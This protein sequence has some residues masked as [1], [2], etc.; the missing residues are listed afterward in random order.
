MAHLISS[1]PLNPDHLVSAKS[2]PTHLVARKETRE[3]LYGP[4]E[5]EVDDSPKEVRQLAT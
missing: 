3:G 1:S 2:Q 5:V 4:Y